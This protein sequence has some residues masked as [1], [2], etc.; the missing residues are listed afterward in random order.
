MS[1][2][3][4]KVL[5]TG[6]LGFIGSSLAIRLVRE[7]AR[8]S[9]C[10]AE[11]SGY[12]A[13]RA[14]IREVRGDVRDRVLSTSATKSEMGRL[15]AG[16]DVVFHLAAQVSH[17]MSLSNPY[18]D[19]DINIRGN[20]GGPGSLP[21]AKPDSDRRSVGHARPVRA[22]RAAPRVRRGALRP[23]RALRDFA[24]LRRDDLP[25]LY[26]HPRRSHGTAASDERLRAARADEAFPVRSRQ[27]VRAPG[28]GRRVRSRSS[29]PE[30]SCGIF[31]TWTTVSM[32]FS[33]PGGSLE[34]SEKSSMSDTTA[35]RLF[36]KSRS[37]C[38]SSFPA[39]RSSSRIS[40]RSAAP[41]NRETSSPT[42][43][44]SANVLGW[45]P[46]VDLRQGLSRTVEFYR[47]RRGDYF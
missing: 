9:I 24:T 42:S 45:E 14:N 2:S 21:Q 31:S 11:I 15:V 36:S 6:G 12:G 35:L 17:V 25:R 13:N 41:R 19:I 8:V 10:D 38:G 28:A 22:G 43:R 23:A 18:P 32:L 1:W 3:G 46:K 30:S 20:R 37:S 39:R 26:A 27:L 29:E 44:R 34:R 4:K 40:A 7:G 5:V 16:Q 33:P 47:E